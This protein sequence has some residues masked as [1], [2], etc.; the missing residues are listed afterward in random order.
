MAIGFSHVEPLFTSWIGLLGLF[1]SLAFAL[2]AL[3]SG[4]ILPGPKFS[5]HRSPF[6]FWSVILTSV[7]IGA[8]LFVWS[9]LIEAAKDAADLRSPSVMSQPL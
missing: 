6:L 4:N 3:W 8:S 5:R 7:I 9:I 2:V 1:G